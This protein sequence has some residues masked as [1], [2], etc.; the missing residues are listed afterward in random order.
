MSYCSPFG[1]DTRLS[2]FDDDEQLVG[3]RHILK[4][5]EHTG[6]ITLI[7]I[8]SSSLAIIEPLRNTVLIPVT[9]TVGAIRVCSA[10]PVLK[11]ALHPISAMVDNIVRSRSQGSRC[12]ELGSFDG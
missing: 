7:I 9:E 10:F 5:T 4:N 6:F 11:H 2:A 8:H 12:R 1:V 3:G